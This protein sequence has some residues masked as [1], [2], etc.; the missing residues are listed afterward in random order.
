M[1]D[2]IDL[3]KHHPQRKDL[4]LENYNN[5]VSKDI[6]NYSERLDAAFDN[7]RRSIKI[8]FF[9]ESISKNKTGLE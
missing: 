2:K 1:Q 5:N 9:M 3:S 8:P 7:V 4:K 6:G